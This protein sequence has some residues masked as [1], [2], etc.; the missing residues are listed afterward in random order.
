[1]QPNGRD[2]TVLGNFFLRVNGITHSVT[3][4]PPHAASLGLFSGKSHK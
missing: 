3:L 4:P 1:M 2:M